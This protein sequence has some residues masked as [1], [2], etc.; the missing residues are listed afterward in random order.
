MQ[1]NWLANDE[2]ICGAL[3]KAAFDERPAKCLQLAHSVGRLMSAVE[4]RAVL[5]GT[6]WVCLALLS[7]NVCKLGEADLG[8]VSVTPVQTAAPGQ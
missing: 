7:L 6:A 5:G 1:G 4:G 3:A 8:S 2:F